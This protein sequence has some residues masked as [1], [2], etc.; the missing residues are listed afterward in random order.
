MNLIKRFGAPKFQDIPWKRWAEGRGKTHHARGWTTDVEGPF[1]RL[2]C[3]GNV[4]RVNGCIK[5]EMQRP[6]KLLTL[7]RTLSPYRKFT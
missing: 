6:R 4:S 3:S 5:F 2:A 7:R 1:I